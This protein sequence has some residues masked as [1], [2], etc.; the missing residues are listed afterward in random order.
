MPAVDPQKIGVAEFRVPDFNRWMRHC[1]VFAIV[2]ILC[3]VNFLH[4]GESRKVD[5]CV[6]GATPSGILAAMA[7]K[8]AGK[9]VVIVE[10]GRWVGG[11]LGAGIKPL[12]D[13]PNPAATGGMTHE[14]L[15]TLGGSP[16]IIRDH[17]SQLIT[18]KEIEVVFEHRPGGVVREGKRTKEVIFDRA[19]FDALG[20]PPESATEK[21]SLRVA[22]AMFID[23]S[24]EG[25]L[26]AQAG[27]SYR[28]DRESTEVFGEEIAGIR[29]PVEW[30]PI[31]PYVTPGDPE[32]G[33]LPWITTTQKEKIGS[34]DPHIQAYNYRF[35]VTDDPEK[36]AP[37]TPPSDYD[38]AQFE[39]VGR[40]VEFL[41]TEFP[42]SEELIVRLRRIFPG[43]MNSGEYNY[44]RNSLITNAPV[45]VS[46]LYADGDYAEKARIWKLHQNYL[47]G[48]HQ[49]LST[50][51]R[52][53]ELF[54][55][56][57]AALGLDLTRHPDTAGW[58]HQLYIRLTRRL[59]GA[60]TITT[61][62]VYNRTTV[63]DPI[64]LAQYGI[65]TYPSRR[66]A[67]EQDGK[68]GV[69]LEG[70]MFV[71]GS[72][73]P[74]RVPYAIPYRA[75]TPLP[76]ESEN[77]LVSICFSASFLGYASARMEP[78]FMICGEAAGMAAC[79]A[80]DEGVPVQAINPK[81]FRAS[82]K[83]AKMVLEWSPER[84]AKA[85][86]L[87]RRSPVMDFFSRADTNRDSFLSAPEWDRLKDSWEWLFPHIDLNHD[88]QLDAAEYSD[89][90]V[91]KATHSD[92]LKRL[93]E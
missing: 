91:F 88:G 87:E 33:L 6:Y 11:I 15:F 17:F 66:V 60:Y 71:G 56:E 45:G 51:T 40:Y 42:D 89:F 26:M 22:A 24:Y 30:T 12:Q 46:H 32:S 9:S 81:E 53:P 34:G 83:E 13:C 78:T 25:E 85:E 27:I 43:W 5:V 14:L 79:R 86:E 23:A 50:D 84:S 35:Y 4:G 67:V 7:V 36:R 70:W 47:C 90:Q 29:E 44:H 8:R 58:P 74:T 61:E 76:E 65:D 93:K 19:P 92:W 68:M 57:T 18:E 64:A 2:S 52:V 75:I 80:I 69:G 72:K 77:V 37:F 62:D 55:E 41:K 10:P 39:L 1:C 54:R 21:A 49:F 28:V 16:E 31:D 63:E 3:T 59:T 73:G 20:C 38:P 82:L 48:L